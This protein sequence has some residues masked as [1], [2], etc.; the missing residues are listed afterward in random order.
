MRLFG[1]EREHDDDFQEGRGGE[2]EEEGQAEEEDVRVHRQPRS[3]QDVVPWSALS[4][5][6]AVFRAQESGWGGGGGGGAVSKTA[7]EVPQEQGE[8]AVHRIS[9]EGGRWKWDECEWNY[10]VLSFGNWRYPESI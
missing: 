5:F 2:W 7:E 10:T 9:G 4:G 3:D 8:E 6:E 1:K